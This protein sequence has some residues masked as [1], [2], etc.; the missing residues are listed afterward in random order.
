MGLYLQNHPEFMFSTVA[1]WSIGSAPALINYNLGGDGLVHCLKIS[2]A[3][4]LLVDEDEG[5]R[6][7]VEEVRDRIENEFGMR[8]YVLDARLKGEINQLPPTR[9]ERK[10]RQNMPGTFP[11]CLMYTR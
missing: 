4:V 5:C 7:R 6:A 1:S 11:M 3:K 8:I 10:Y 2:G 9:P